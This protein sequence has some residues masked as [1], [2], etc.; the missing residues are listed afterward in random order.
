MPATTRVKQN[1]ES[2]EKIASELDGLS[3]SLRIAKADMERSQITDIEVG[4]YSSVLMG[5]ER[6]EAF[7]SAVRRSLKQTKESRGDYR[8]DKPTEKPDKSAPNRT[9]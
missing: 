5:L 3:D 8:A 4:S 1:P 7:V 9:S 2:I 6:I